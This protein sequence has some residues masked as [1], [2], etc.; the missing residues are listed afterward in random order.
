M[1]CFYIGAICSKYKA[2]K[3]IEK[4]FEEKNLELR[5]KLARAGKLARTT[6]CWTDT[7]NQTKAPSQ[8][9]VTSS[10]LTESRV[11]DLFYTLYIVQH[12]CQSSHNL[13]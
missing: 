13:W 12:I 7:Q 6:D 3:G 10:M 4:H 2:E 8:L 11:S 5:A 9:P 1:V